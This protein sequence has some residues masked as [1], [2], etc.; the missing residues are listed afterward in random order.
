MKKITEQLLVDLGFLRVEVSEEESG[1]GKGFYYFTY[2][3]TD[4]GSFSLITNA[5]DEAED[6]SWTVEIFEDSS[7]RFN[8]ETLVK[9][10]NVMK[11]VLNETTQ[12]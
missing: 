10:M 7:V 6:D 2:D 5:N 1:F 12:R 4:T 3:F 8:S 9:F 11:E